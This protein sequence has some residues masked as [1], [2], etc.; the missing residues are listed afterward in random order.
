MEKFLDGM[1]K[2]SDLFC[3]RFDNACVRVNKTFFRFKAGKV[4]KACIENGA[5]VF[6]LQMFREKGSENRKIA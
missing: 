3:V 6:V 2:Y 4:G 1:P 5:N